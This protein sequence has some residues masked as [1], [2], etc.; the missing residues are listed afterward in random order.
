LG[1]GNQISEGKMGTLQ[2]QQQQ[3][4]HYHSQP[5]KQQQ[6]LLRQQQH[7]RQQQ[8][9]HDQIIQLH[10]IQQQSEKILKNSG[11]GQLFDGI[12]DPATLALRAGVCTT[13]TTTTAAA[14]A[15]TAGG[16]TNQEIIFNNNSVLGQQYQQQNITIA[17]G[18]QSQIQQQQKQ[19]QHQ[20]QHQPFI[21]NNSDGA[22]NSHHH[23]QQQQRHQNYQQNTTE[24]VTKS[25]N[26]N[27][28]SRDNSQQKEIGTVD[29]NNK[30]IN[31]L[32]TA[33]KGTQNDTR[34]LSFVNAQQHGSNEATNKKRRQKA[35]KTKKSFP[36]Q[37][38]DAMAGHSDR[39]DAFEWLPD[40][41][42]FVIINWDIFCN[43]ILDKTLK[44]SKYGSFVRKLHRWG[45][46]RL[47]SGT[48]TD[49]FH[50]PLFQRSLGELVKSIASSVTKSS[51]GKDDNKLLS[52]AM[53]KAGEPSLL[54][55]EKFAKA[56][57]F[58][59][60]G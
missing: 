21:G 18:F 41:K 13:T 59:T 47:T 40:G 17:Y 58:S 46:V 37:L 44:A 33:T 12:F 50:H 22:L 27:N 16:N 60:D 24:A 57:V 20:H 15:A 30:N 35:P 5:R 36:K 51:G 28:F 31:R 34:L 55:V 19:H 43:D 11:F 39:E 9:I 48:G 6:E 3:Q 54:G 49:C 53:R 52:I 29:N 4:Q 23:H 38:W 26:N 32:S 14:A 1:G 42:S 10:K 56:N 8:Q 25:V 2:Q 45:F 7:Q